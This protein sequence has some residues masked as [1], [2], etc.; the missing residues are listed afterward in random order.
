MGRRNDIKL[1]RRFSSLTTGFVSIL[2]LSLM[3]VSSTY[4]TSAFDSYYNTT[5]NLTVGSTYSTAVCTDVDVSSTWSSY[6]TDSSKWRSGD[7]WSTAKASFQSA[8]AN[9]SSG[10][11][12]ASQESI[13]LFGAKSVLFFWSEDSSTELSWEDNIGNDGV[14]I[15]T[16][17]GSTIHYASIGCQ[18][19]QYG[20]G[21]DRPI[22]ITT[23]T[24]SRL[25]IS[26]SSSPHFTTLINQSVTGGVTQN[27]PS[28][29]AGASI[30]TTSTIPKS[31]GGNIQCFNGPTGIVTNV[32]VTPSS[33]ATG[34]AT[35]SDDGGSGVNYI[36]YPSETPSSYNLS[37]TCGAA[38]QPAGPADPDN[39]LYVWYCSTAVQSSCYNEGS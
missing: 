39:N 3:P 6:L 24:V 32:Y 13:S 22:V 35:L 18:K 15:K 5:S 9:T 12:G 4:A 10:I 14:Y 31:F 25:E 26:T 34:D 23:G 16:S 1:I 8:R 19:Y 21:V 20:D 2:S 28:G 33:G 36:Y 7:D 37:I 29:Y 30:A 17:G 38:T 11:W 27:L